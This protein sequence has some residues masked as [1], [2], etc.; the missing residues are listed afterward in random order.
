M[1]TSDVNDETDRRIRDRWIGICGGLGIDE[2]D[3]KSSWENYCVARNDY[4]LD[5]STHFYQLNVAHTQA[6]S[7]R[8]ETLGL[9]QFLIL[10]SFK[11]KFTGRSNPLA[12][13]CSV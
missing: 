2:S 8:C 3:M 5:V 13:L 10:F 1:L 4:T 11:I 9:Q 7:I 12:V 6:H